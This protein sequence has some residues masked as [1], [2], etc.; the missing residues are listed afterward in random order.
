MVHMDRGSEVCGFI[1]ADCVGIP[2]N[3][4]STSGGIFSVGSTK[5]SWYKR[6]HMFVVL[7]ARKTKYMAT[8]QAACEVI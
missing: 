7:S 2:S 6:K 4:K 8:S 1:D 5:I 3:L